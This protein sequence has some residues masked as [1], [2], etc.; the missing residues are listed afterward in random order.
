[1]SKHGIGC[2]DLGQTLVE[3]RDVRRQARKKHPGLTHA[4]CVEYVI[5]TTKEGK[6]LYAESSQERLRKAM[7]IT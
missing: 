6:R 7:R 4:Q 3:Q 5:T 1:M 2:D